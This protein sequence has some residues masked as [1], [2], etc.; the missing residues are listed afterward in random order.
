[1]TDIAVY[2]LNVGQANCLAIL[3]PLPGGRIGEFQ[4]ALVDVGV[5]SDSL[6]RWLNSNNVRYL[7]VIALSHNDKDHIQGLDGLVHQYRKR[8]GQVWFLV[9]RKPSEIPY[10]VAA[11]EWVQKGF[12]RSVDVLSAPAQTRRGDGKV[13]LGPP[14]AAYHLFCLYPSVFANLAAVQGADVVGT[15]PGRGHNATSA[16][17][18]LTTASNPKRIRVLF[19]GDLGFRGWQTLVEARIRLDA[20]VFVVP[21][22]GGPK[23]PHPTFGYAQ[24]AHEVSPRFALL[25]VGTN[26]AYGHPHPELVAALCAEGATILCTQLTRH[27][28]DDPDGVPNGSV[29]PLLPLHPPIDLSSSGTA[30]AGTVMVVIRANGRLSVLR[31]ADHQKAVNALQ[32]AGHHPLCRP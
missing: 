4:A 2:C 13:L 10:W 14:R 20:D 18:A 5:A 31:L 23:A 3:E 16:V 1:V 9:D 8:I 28:H 17:L 30:C 12:V 22:H 7:P 24:L 32:D 11:Q 15:H 25:S 29:L 6:G 19:G 21:H 27:C 26:Q